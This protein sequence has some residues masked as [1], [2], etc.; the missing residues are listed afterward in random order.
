VKKCLQFYHLLIPKLIIQIGV[1]CC[2]SLHVFA[3]RTTLQDKSS[4]CFVCR[5]FLQCYYVN[6]TKNYF[7][8][9]QLLT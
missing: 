4:T 6:K 7:A 1:I 8:S 3:L 2:V 5:Y 9:Q